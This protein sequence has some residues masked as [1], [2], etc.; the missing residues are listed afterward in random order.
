VQEVE[1]EDD[2]IA[3]KRL[4][5]GPLDALLQVERHGC[6]VAVPGIFGCQPRFD[7]S[8]FTIEEQQGLI[9]HTLGAAIDSTGEWVEIAGPG[10]FGATH[11]VDDTIRLV[12]GACAA[13]ATSGDGDDQSSR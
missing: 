10:A 2:V 1:R 7:A 9:D 5:I 8:I 12:T 3:G 11:D 4:A 6:A 13:G